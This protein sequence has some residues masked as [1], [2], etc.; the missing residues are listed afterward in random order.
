M[1]NSLGISDSLLE[2]VFTAL[3]HGTGSIEQGGP[4]V[5]F[6]M[7]EGEQR[8][9]TRFVAD[10]YGESVARAREH[11]ACPSGSTE[12]WALAYDG[13]VTLEGVRTDAIFV[14][15]GKRGI[16]HRVIFAQ[17]YQAGPDGRALRPIGNA[18]YLGKDESPG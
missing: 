15:A 4:L 13:I 17:R 16:Y 2:L 5:P 6:V 1:P 11:V 7:T 9:L 10:K 18:A 14:E 8:Q 12:R 3:D